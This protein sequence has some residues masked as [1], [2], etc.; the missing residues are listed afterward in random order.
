[1]G[2]W[3]EIHTITD[4]Y[5]NEE[6]MVNGMACQINYFR[7]SLSVPRCASPLLQKL[8]LFRLWAFAGLHSLAY[9]NNNSWFDVSVDTSLILAI[10]TSDVFKRFEKCQRA[11]CFIECMCVK[12]Y[13]CVLSLLL[14]K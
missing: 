6:N 13:I 9:L 5:R 2:V 10:V 12:V 1:M 14:G 3:M 4:F 11:S 7:T 8:I